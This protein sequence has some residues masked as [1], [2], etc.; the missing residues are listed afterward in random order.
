MPLLPM[1]GTPGS[2]W[3]VYRARLK[4]LFEGFDPRIYGAFW[5]FGMTSRDSTPRPV[6]YG[7]R[8]G[9]II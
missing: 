8:M 9:Y 5:L 3:A 6:G 2:S 7:S 1:P 4:A